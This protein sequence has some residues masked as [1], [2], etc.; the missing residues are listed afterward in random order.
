[1]GEQA[2]KFVDRRSFLQLGIGLG[3][4]SFA[5]VSQGG[6]SPLPSGRAGQGQ[7]VV[8]GVTQSAS[9]SLLPL[10]IAHELGYFRA[11]GLALDWVPMVSEA[12][13]AA[14]LNKGELHF[15]VSDFV[16]ALTG[17]ARGFDWKAIAFPSRTPQVVFGVLPRSVSSYRHLSDLKGRRVCTLPSSLTSQLLISQ[18]KQGAGLAPS[19]ISI[20]SLNDPLDALLQIRLGN[21]DALCMDHAMV[22]ALEQR[23]E[24]KVIVDTRTSQGAQDGFGGPMPGS[25]V[26]ASA[27]F[28]QQ[29]AES[30][31]AL[32]YAVARALRWLRTAGPSDLV[33]ALSNVTLDTDL[34]YYLAALEK[35]RDGFLGDGV[36]PDAAAHTGLRALNRHESRQVMSGVRLTQ[37][38]TNE[39]ALKAKA[40]FRI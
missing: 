25:A 18:L 21:M 33:R 22:A 7:R 20:V 28:V 17:V 6:S 29:R 39:F 30:C 3:V 32:A 13:G 24:L 23:G 12:D 26:C 8:M 1:M 2:Y 15:L 14:A 38:Y 34:V 31:Q 35:S 11:E 5:G 9:L 27:Q 19:D 40:R 37:S 36:M 16:Y 10:L 4:G